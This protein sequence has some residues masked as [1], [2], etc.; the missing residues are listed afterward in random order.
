MLH[1]TYNWVMSCVSDPLSVWHPQSMWWNWITFLESIGI[2]LFDL[3][4]HTMG[5]LPFY[6]FYSKT[7]L[8]KYGSWNKTG[9]NLSCNIWVN[10]DE[11][12]ANAKVLRL[13]EIVSQFAKSLNS[14][15][16]NFN[17]TAVVVSKICSPT[18][19]FLLVVGG[20][21]H[22]SERFFFLTM[23]VRVFRRHG[24]QGWLGGFLKWGYP[25]I[26]HF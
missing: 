23:R 9:W 18:I 19:S 25:Q 12:T 5:Y 14:C 8:A 21:F 6:P 2:L 20:C 3:H 15:N 26:I 16:F 7:Q 13:F 17:H 24:G 4:G 10:I 11:W 1:A 22:G